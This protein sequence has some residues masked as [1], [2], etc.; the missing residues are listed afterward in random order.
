MYFFSYCEGPFLRDII[1]VINFD[2]EFLCLESD[3]LSKVDDKGRCDGRMS[4]LCFEE[5]NVFHGLD[6]C[7]RCDSGVS[8]FT[9]AYIDRAECVLHCFQFN[10]M[11]ATL[12]IVCQDINAFVPNVVFNCC[13]GGG[14]FERECDRH[15][16][17]AM[18]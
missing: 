8:S 14:C 6:M 5:S 7:G 2:I 9:C 10:D 15:V 1:I 12:S 4:T 17:L 13:R 18:M 3:S 16:I 11:N